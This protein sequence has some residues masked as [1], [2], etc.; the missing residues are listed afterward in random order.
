VPAAALDRLVERRLLHTEERLGAQR[1]EIIHDVLV[2]VIRKSRE[3]RH[4]REAEATARLR[5]AEAERRRRAEDDASRREAEFR[6]ERHRRRQAYAMLAVMAALV[7]VAVVA[8]G[9]AYY[10]WR[11]A[12][13]R[14]DIAD[15]LAKG[16]S[17]A[18]GW[19]VTRN[20]AEAL[21]W[22]RK[23]ADQDDATAQ[24][25]MGYVYYYGGSGVM[26]DHAEAFVWLRRAAEQ[27]DAEAEHLIGVMY[28]R[29]LGVERDYRQAFRWLQKAANQGIGFAQINLGMMYRDGQG[30]N[31]DYAEA[32][33]WYLKAA[34]QGNAMAQDAV[35]WIYEEG[36]VVEQDYAEAAR[37][38][39]MAGEQ[40]YAI[41]QRN[42]ALLYASGL[43]VSHNLDQARAWM[44]KAATQDPEA[45]GWLARD[46]GANADYVAA[47]EERVTTAVSASTETDEK[48]SLADALGGLSWSLTL[49]N[50][51]SDAL[52]RAD[53]A[54]RLNPSARWVALLRAYALLVL[55]RFDEA[56]ALYL[57]LTSEKKA[58][59]NRSDFLDALRHDFTE[60][61]GSSSDQLD[62]KKVQAFSLRRIG[63]LELADGDHRGGLAAYEESLHIF[64][65]LAQDNGNTIAQRELLVSLRKVHDTRQLLGDDA[66]ARAIAE[67]IGIV[68]GHL[69]NDLAKLQ[70][71]RHVLLGGVWSGSY[72]CRQ[73]ETGVDLVFDELNDDGVVHANFTFFSL[74]G[75][76]NAESGKYSLFG[77]YNITENQLYM[78]PNKWIRMAPNYVPVGFTASSPSH[79]S[80]TITGIIASPGCNQIHVEKKD[81][82]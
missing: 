62:M 50:R 79:E 28:W 25:Y 77:Q 12:E 1:I 16:S 42:L 26:Q 45:R 24:K 38:Y 81:S 23:A 37:W 11:E 51:A 56:N 15:A 33:K 55:D 80:Y 75:K 82:Q 35:G 63:D 54:L 52:A 9:G 22:F 29:G 70:V 7:V 57:N 2:R 43:G 76:N 20:F 6:R 4:L 39:R 65:E 78:T 34:D 48:R 49:N 59:E 17:Y 3:A 32:L 60:L 8:A 31:R 5:E 67:A 19:G 36:R 44:Q 10:F 73:G 40:G 66:G 21:R 71:V 41:A 68:D 53:E 64:R 74:S 27:G 72:L 46:A 30:M 69:T 61:H 58:S 47:E 14:G 18:N 13:R